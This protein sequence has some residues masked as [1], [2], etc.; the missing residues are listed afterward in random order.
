MP[1]GVR[2]RTYQR[3]VAMDEALGERRVNLI[4][5]RFLKHLR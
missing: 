5:G 2:R 4:L 1:R 3:L